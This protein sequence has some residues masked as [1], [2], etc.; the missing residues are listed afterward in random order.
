MQRS[1]KYKIFSCL[2]FLFAWHV[3]QLTSADGFGVTVNKAELVIED[4]WYIVNADVDFQ[5]SQKAIDALKSGIPL[6][7]DVRIRIQQERTFLWNKTVFEKNLPYQIRYYPL[8]NIYQF[9]GKKNKE[10]TSFI[11][12][13]P[14]LEAM[15]KLRG[16]K[17]FKKN[18]FQKNNHYLASIRIRFDR[19]ALP[20]PLRPVSY[21]DSSWNLS[22][23]WLVWSAP[24]NNRA[25]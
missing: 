21:F 19:E 3:P 7:W 10:R 17:L 24:V 14:A 18:Y 8:L 15:G 2:F 13:M 22:G 5:L 9:K 11:S 6:A 1:G 16:V 12:L 20:L 23:D 25:E 4:G